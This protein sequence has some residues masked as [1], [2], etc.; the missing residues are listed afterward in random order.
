[1]SGEAFPA[2]LLP[3][4]YAHA[5]AT[6]PEE[7]C[8]YVL[9]Q[10]A[11]ARYVACVNRQNRLHELDPEA[12][13]RTAANAYNIGGRELLNLVR[14]F[15]EGPAATAIVHSHPR[16]GAY[17]SEED[18]RAALAAGYPVDY[19]VVDAQETH[20]GGAVLFRRRGDGFEEVARYPGGDDGS[21]H[22]GG[23]VGT[24]GPG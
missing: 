3:E 9:G 15:E 2:A 12:N 24:D 5:R 19:L 18:T 6:F 1:M 8:G 20:I 7:C 10:G 21:D 23:D 16:V 11:D 14:S 17:F 13:P 22:R 4:I